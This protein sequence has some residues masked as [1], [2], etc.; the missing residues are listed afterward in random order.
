MLALTI[1]FRVDAIV[2]VNRAVNEVS[3]NVL[4]IYIHSRGY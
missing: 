1:V 2:T 4:V 3:V